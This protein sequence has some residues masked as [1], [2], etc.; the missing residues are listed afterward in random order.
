MRDEARKR[1]GHIY[2]D[3]DLPD[4]YGGGKATVIAWLWAR[5][6]TCPN[7]GC[8]FRTP[9]AKSFQLSS[10]TPFWSFPQVTETGVKFTVRPGVATVEGTVK[11]RGARCLKC[12]N[13]VGLDY[14]AGQAR[15]GQLGAQLLAIVAEGSRRRVYLS[16]DAHS[17][18]AGS[19]TASTIPHW[20]P[21]TA[22]PDAALGFRVQRYGLMTHASLFSERQRVALSTLCDLVGEVRK[23][24][25]KVDRDYADSVATYLAF[26]VSKA[27]NYWSTL[28]SWYVN[29]EIMVS[30]FGLPTL[31]M[32]W[33]YAEANP[34]STSTGNWMLG[35]QQAA[36][37]L[38]GLPRNA[39]PGTASQRSATD[40]ATHVEAACIQTDP[41]YY[42]NIGYANLADF[43]MCGCAARSARSGPVFSP[44]C[45]R[46]RSMN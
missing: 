5:T 23:Q 15:A 20:A 9:L 38:E 8:E 44:L 21:E 14:V 29:K 22:L 40:A 7:P 30:T 34:F 26:A 11:N 12:L 42:D 2:P 25:M 4:E 36:E 27:A 37:V 33:D 18:Q 16:P 39:P 17:E 6:V 31:S 24:L 10:R 43:F 13:P 32:V 1:I 19:A 35:V 45:S 41:P 3:V 28:C 46:P